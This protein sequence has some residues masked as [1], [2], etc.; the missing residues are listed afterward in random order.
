MI[1]LTLAQIADAKV[2]FLKMETSILG[3]RDH[4]FTGSAIIS[5]DNARDVDVVVKVLNR[6]EAARKLIEYDSFELYGEHYPPNTTS[7]FIALRR[8]H[9]NLIL[10]DSTTHFERWLIATDTAHSL[11]LTRKA[12]RIALFELIRSFS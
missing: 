2:E 8:G 3:Y 11:R 4:L 12:D 1:R 7:P 10:V 9:L 6:A 5:P